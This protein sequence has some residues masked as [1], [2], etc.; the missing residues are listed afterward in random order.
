MATRHAIRLLLLGTWHR[1]EGYD[2]RIKWHG[3]HYNLIARSIHSSLAP[4][5]CFLHQYSSMRNLIHASY[6]RDSKYPTRRASSV[7]DDDYMKVGKTKLG[8][9]NRYLRHARI[10]RLRSGRADVGGQMMATALGNRCAFRGVAGMR[11]SA[12]S[13]CLGPQ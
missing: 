8:R 7:R 11:I 4:H 10:S 3:L 13:F 6:S 5:N 1:D 12:T 9:H 2:L